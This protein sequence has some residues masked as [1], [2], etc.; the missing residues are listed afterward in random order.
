MGMQPGGQMST[1]VQAI[2]TR[3][4]EGESR[5]EE[6]WGNIVESRFSVRIREWFGATAALLAIFCGLA[7]VGVPLALSGGAGT[8]LD[9]ALVG[10]VT[11]L[12]ALLLAG[13]TGWALRS[14]SPA[15]RAVTGTVFGSLALVASVLA[16]FKF[17][18]PQTWHVVAAVVGTCIIGPASFFAYNQL[19]D[20]VD[21]M[22]WVSALE[23]QLAPVYR[24]LLEEELR[25]AKARAT[26]TRPI[27]RWEHNGR[28]A[29]HVS[30][31][32]GGGHEPEPFPDVDDEPTE[33]PDELDL[34]LADFL[35]EAMR[36]GLSRRA[37]L[38]AGASRHQLP[39]TGRR[40]TRPVYD[41]L[42][43]KA[44]QEGF[45]VPGGDGSGHEWAVDPRDALDTWASAVEGEWG[46]LLDVAA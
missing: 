31:R 24:A 29:R 30:A 5:I 42:I 38:G 18:E 41:A 36:R 10:V 16:A 21:P 1:F 19:R 44:T 45:I 6:K 14:A 26:V 46:D 35:A 12:V 23:G 40:V 43:E 3:S 17:G 25:Q 34:E 27:I 32:D 8:V 11:G 2:L 28:H 15:V 33:V 37:W 9:V 4:V 13:V 7:L 39:T 20:L 22:G